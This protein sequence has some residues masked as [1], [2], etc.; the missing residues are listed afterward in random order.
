MTQ[1]LLEAAA[2]LSIGQ[3]LPLKA[4]RIGLGAQEKRQL[5]GTVESLS[6]RAS[7]CNTNSQSMLY[8]CQG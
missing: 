3:P 1:Y 5:L 7:D 4:A 6:T 2:K 8:K